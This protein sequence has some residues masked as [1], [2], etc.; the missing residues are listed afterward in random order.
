MH[1]LGYTHPGE[2]QLPVE[3]LLSSKL[4]KALR[5]E[6]GCPTLKQGFSG[7]FFSRTRAAWHRSYSHGR[8]CLELMNLDSIIYGRR[9]CSHCGSESSPSTGNRGKLISV[10]G[11]NFF[12]L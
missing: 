4:C 5:G 3:M 2:V 7:I 11:F 8:H 10:E 6:W 9:T 12:W 1:V